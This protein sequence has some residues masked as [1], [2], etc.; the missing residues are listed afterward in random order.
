MRRV[1]GGVEGGGTK[2]KLLIGTDPHDI[3]AQAQI[4][5]TTPDETLERVIA[6]FRR[7]DIEL[8]AVGCAS[9]GPIDL[10]TRSPTY[11]CITTTPKPGWAYTNV[12]RTLGSELGV[13]VAWETDTAGAALGEYTWGA[14]RHIE[15]LV[16]VTVGTGIGGAVLINGRPVHGL[17][18]AEMGHV[19][20]PVA[21]GDT[22]AGICPY[23][24]QCL[25]GMAS[26]PALRA[27]TG[28]PGETIAPD[29]PIWDLEA[30][31]LGA[32][33][34]Q[35]GYVLSPQKIIVGGGVPQTPHLLEKI[36]R[37]VTSLNHGYLAHPALSGGIRD[38]I[39][40]PG[41]GADAGVI[42]ALELARQSLQ[43]HADQVRP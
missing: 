41:L 8:A 16:Y 11:G 19:L 22:F 27:R 37:Q 23:H 2:F 30:A 5:T 17:L 40:P 12:V 20:V 21:D 36:R 43:S 34:H 32:G 31:Y 24:G 18:H 25:E 28:R 42:G 9:F 4:P 13:P 39:V 1:F 6:F 14:G 29:D 26:G 38:Y 15:V 7:P 3:V 33:L 35:I 10:D